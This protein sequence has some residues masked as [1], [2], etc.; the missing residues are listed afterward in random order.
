MTIINQYWA[1]WLL[2]FWSIFSSAQT[3]R[4]I[5][6]FDQTNGA[7][8]YYGALVQG[9]DGA[10]YGTTMV[11][12]QNT[13]VPD[14]VAFRVT[15]NGDFSVLYN[16]CTQDGCSDGNGPR[17]GMVLGTDGNLYGTTTFGGNNEQLGTIYEIGRDGTLRTLYQFN[18]STDGACPQDSLIEA[19]D[20]DFYGTTNCGGAYQLG[21]VFRITPTGTFT[22]LH[23]FGGPD[24]IEP[25][26]GTIQ[27]DDGSLFGTTPNGGINS[28]KD[29]C[30]VVF[31][32][33]PSGVFSVVHAFSGS[34]GQQ[35]YGT[36]TQASDGN[37]YGT[38]TDGGAFG[39]GTIFTMGRN[40]T[41]RI[42]HSF[43]HSDGAYPL[44]KL[45]EGTDGN[46][47]CTK[48]SKGGWLAAFTLGWAVGAS[49]APYKKST[50]GSAGT[51]G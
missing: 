31:R 37:I 21:T 22:A 8:P 51:R 41:F 45:I 29:G 50:T 43:D 20:G 44:G 26:A 12:G 39:Y 10:L 34:D 30:G 40:G 36:L 2:I 28:C 19:T 32:I 48:K 47:R 14:G 18:Y 27:T 11:G 7:A 16:F 33:T 46:D 49:F 13:G 3:F 6:N 24:G 42:V 23:D 1:S 5:V 4:T 9:T 17:G 35:P 38:T 15:P 25:F